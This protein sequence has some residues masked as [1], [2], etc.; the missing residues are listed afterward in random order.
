MKN[1]LVLVIVALMALILGLQYAGRKK[2]APPAEPAATRQDGTDGVSLPT[3][4]GDVSGYSPIGGPAG[5]FADLGAYDADKAACEGGSIGEIIAAYDKTWGPKA[6][7]SPYALDA[8]D[9][10]KLQ[11]GLDEYFYCRAFAVQ[12][13]AACDSLSGQPGFSPRDCQTDLAEL[14]TFMYTAGKSGDSSFCVARLKDSEEDYPFLKGKDLIAFCAAAAKGC[15]DL[16]SADK[17]QCLTVFPRSKGDCA[18]SPEE[19]LEYYGLYAAI[20]SGDPDKCPASHS[21][22]CRAFLNKTI[23]ECS[24]LAISVSRHYCAAVDKARATSPE[25]MAERHEAAQQAERERLER[26]KILQE[27]NKEIKKTIGKK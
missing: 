1:W 26:E 24:S 9:T 5:G 15:E 17:K 19:C 18:G 16:P 8:A 2:V 27:I 13:S 22:S 21:V 23:A 10:K 14:M 12:D 6:G 25:A 7:D 4:A 20:K 3:G 11:R